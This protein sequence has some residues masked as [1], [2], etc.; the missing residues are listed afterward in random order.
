MSIPIEIQEIAIDVLGDAY[1]PSSL[2]ACSLV[3]RAWLP[4]SR[5]NL[6]RSISLHPG[7]SLDNLFDLFQEKPFFRSVVERISV[8]LRGGDSPDPTLFE[9]IPIRLIGTELPKLRAFTFRDESRGATLPY[10]S[11]RPPSP[12]VLQAIFVGGD[13]THRP[14]CVPHLFRP[15]TARCCLSVTTSSPFGPS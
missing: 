2:R 10:I 12:R 11:L 3:C 9:T 14:P 5:L 6:F 15:R 7:R 4:R 1:D 13:T 8:S